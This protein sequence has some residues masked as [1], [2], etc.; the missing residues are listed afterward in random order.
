MKSDKNNDQIIS[1]GEANL[2]A[3]RIRIQLHEYGVEF[4]SEKFVRFIGNNPSVTGLIAIAQKLLQPEDTRDTSEGNS[5]NEDLRDMIYVTNNDIT[6]V[7][8]GGK[9]SKSTNR[10]PDARVSLTS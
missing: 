1:R 5:E 8:A 3:L 4:D 6:H 2:L 10:N 9:G 7:A